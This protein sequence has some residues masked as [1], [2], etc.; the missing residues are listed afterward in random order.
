M[1]F[2]SK[3]VEL[4]DV[5]FQWLRLFVPKTYTNDRGEDQDK[6]EA[7]IIVEPDSESD[8]R[9]KAA[10]DEIAEEQFGPKWQAVL[11][12]IEQDNRNCY[13]SGDKKTNADGEIHD[14]FADMMFFRASR[15]SARKGAPH[16]YNQFGERITPTD[17]KEFTGDRRPPQNGDYGVVTINFWVLDGNANQGR[18]IVADLELCMV[19]QHGEPFTSG[20]VN[21]DVAESM[22]AKYA[23]VA[24]PPETPK[25]E[26][27]QK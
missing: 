17:F 22:A 5:R 13:K 15:D 25:V 4:P 7:T 20:G 8:K 1:A 23:K 2:A 14:G 12:K 6:F 19:T 10:I 27:M 26:G 3:Q 9:I 11:K 18:R 21:A 24:P 16:S